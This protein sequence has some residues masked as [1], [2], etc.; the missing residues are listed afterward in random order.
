MA[1]LRYLTE[2]NNI[3]RTYDENECLKRYET[4]LNKSERLPEIIIIRVS[5]N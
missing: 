2:I 5:D 1:T 3:F 4:I